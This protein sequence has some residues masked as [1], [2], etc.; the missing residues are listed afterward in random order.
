MREQSQFNFTGV[1]FLVFAVIFGTFLVLVNVMYKNVK[2]VEATIINLHDQMTNT[3]LKL[4]SINKEKLEGAE[5]PTPKLSYGDNWQNFVHQTF[6]FQFKS[7][8]GWG[9][10][11]F[12][13]QG[14]DTPIAESPG[15]Y[16]IGKFNFKPASEIEVE[17]KTKDNRIGKM[18]SSEAVRSELAASD[19][20]DCGDK[21]FEALKAL[22][23][24]EIRNCIVKENILNQKYLTFRFVIKGEETA[25]GTQS[26]ALYPMSN[27]YLA[28]LYPD[29]LSEE[30]I[31]FIQSFVFE[32][33]EM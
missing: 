7:P 25:P 23:I 4:E 11:D 9:N 5:E 27:Y 24:G 17:L 22:D 33:S 12:K 32:T 8:V 18:Y 3:T 6:G 20:G 13:E 2:Q 26:I 29:N 31:A 10:F 14:A 16:F 28:V 1:I 15:K 21:L 30:E 19:N